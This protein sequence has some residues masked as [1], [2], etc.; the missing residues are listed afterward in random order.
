MARANGTAVIMPSVSGH[1]TGQ[2]VWAAVL[3]SAFLLVIFAGLQIIGRPGKA[4]LRDDDA[5]EARTRPSVGWGR[6]GSLVGLDNRVST[7]R[8]IA[9]LWTVVLGYCLLALVLISTAKHSTAAPPPA[10]RIPSGFIDSALKPLA[11][12]YIV[13]LG[14]PFAAAVSARVIVGQQI[15]K[16]VLQKSKSTTPANPIQI[17]TDDEGNLDLVDLQYTLFNLIA[18]TFVLT[19][20]I[21]NPGHGVPTIPASLAILTGISAGVYT[22]NKAVTSNP[23]DI[24]DVLTPSVLPGQTASITGHNLVINP[25]NSDMATNATNTKVSLIPLRPPGQGDD[26]ADAASASVPS[27]TVA[28]SKATPDLVEFG[29]P[30]DLPAGPRNVRLRTNAGGTAII[31]NQLTVLSPARPSLHR[32]GQDFNGDNH[33][34]PPELPADS[35]PEPA[36]ASSPC[37]HEASPERVTEVRQT[38]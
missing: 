13:L 21:P 10:G 30:A 22:A 15:A 17:V 9:F 12:A 37:T 34:L 4:S 32:P 27:V 6:L 18:A 28:A 14:A 29:V 38:T 16:G 26:T 20:F 3:L 35:E 8:T 5:S 23:P 31:R 33:R 11:P 2:Q 24:T 36:E 25:D 19:Q 1:F 7:S